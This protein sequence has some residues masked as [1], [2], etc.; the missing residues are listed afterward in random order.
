[1]TGHWI[2][3]TEVFD[4][5]TLHECAAIRVSDGHVVEIA[6]CPTDFTPI[7][8]LI[9]PGCV[10]LQVNG[11]GGVMLNTTPTPDGIRDIVA[12]HRAAGT[13]WVLPTVITDAPD[14]LDRA[15]AAILAAMEEPG[16]LGL[17]IEGPHISPAKRGVHAAEFIRDM[18]DRTI[19]VVRRMRAENV[20]VMITVAPE[21]VMLKQIR[22]LVDLGAV[23]SIGHTDAV[24]DDVRA[25]IDAGA[26]CGTHLFNAMS[27]MQGRAPGA[28]G[29]L[30]TSDCFTGIICD[31][32][33]VDDA[34]IALAIRARPLPDR[35]FLVSDAMAT[36]GGPESFDL[37]D[38][39]IS[40]KG[41]RLLNGD[42]ALAGTHVTQI[43]G[44]KRLV[45][46]VGVSKTEALRMVTSV[47]A[48]CI[49]R[50]ALGR[51]IGRPVS[52]VVVL[53]QA[54]KFQGTLDEIA[55]SP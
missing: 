36:V 3:A 15:A 37:Y 20:P 41:G 28:V 2:S 6:D 14:V 24:T 51:L 47:P 54:L 45:D 25:A 42:G 26:T 43:E 39:R 5:D 40:L 8:G 10:D 19:G 44:M 23:V 17:H 22:Q 49:G 21:A 33:H 18:D 27:Q 34:M 48:E 53:D 46:K 50:P 1:M 4:G 55:P 30:I 16:V 31:G 52:E 9:A 29:A 38:E 13:M 35:V 32:H 7:A 12:A 11:G